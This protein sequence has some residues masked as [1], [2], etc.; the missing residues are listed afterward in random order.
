MKIYFN[1]MHCDSTAAAPLALFPRSFSEL[2]TL[3]S[4]DNNGRAVAKPS[5]A[6]KFQTPLEEQQAKMEIM[7]LHLSQ[8]EQAE[9]DGKH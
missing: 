3:L 4:T 2:F 9:R 7:R 1:K 6:V 8:A 5:S